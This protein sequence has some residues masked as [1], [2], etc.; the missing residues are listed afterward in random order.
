MVFN[1]LEDIPDLSGKACLITGGNTGL[2]AA[3]IKFLA[4]H[5]PSVIYLCA[6]P[7]SIPGAEAL[8]SSIKSHF[9]EVNIEILS[10][11]LSSMDNIFKFGADFL[12]KAERLD[13]LFLNAG[14]SSTL[15]ALTDD[16]YESQ[17]GINHVGHALLTQ[18]LMPKLL[19][20][21]RRGSQ[22]RIMVTSSMAAHLDP[23][24]T[25]LLLDDMKKADALASPY[26]RYAHSKV[27]A[28]LFARKLA[29]MYPS[30]QS[31]SFN[32]GQVK[33]DLFKKATGINKWVMMFLGMPFM[34]LTGVS[35]E[36]GAENGLWVAFAHDVK[37]GAY[38]E[39]VGVLEQDKKFFTD[40]ELA[41]E[42]WRWTSEELAAHGA[43]GWPAA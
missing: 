8:V 17:F 33:T 40:Q 28:I 26:Q 16:G 15:P 5:N 9:P 21:G 20:T 42:L 23:P 43:P 1:P 2:G 4:R 27:A 29:Q 41:D 14:I 31:V 36:K 19:E 10:L 35:P 13:L 38:Y 37:N 25:G 11:D 32:P 39:P 24:P 12:Q 7:V 6:R 34:W 3:T 22:V 30:I 18:L